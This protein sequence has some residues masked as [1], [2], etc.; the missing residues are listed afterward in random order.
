MISN[1]LID[2]KSR[3]PAYS[4]N[5][6][7]NY[8]DRQVAVKTGTTNDYKDVWVV[9][10]T[11]SL[12]LGMWGG[13]NDNAPVTRTAGTVLSPSW[14]KSMDAALTK[15][16]IEYF[17]TPTYPE[18]IPAYLSGST[19]INGQ[20]QPL[21]YYLNGPSDPQ[22]N[23]W[24]NPIQKWNNEKGVCYSQSQN[25]NPNNNSTTTPIN[26]NTTNNSTSTN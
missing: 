16:S 1:V 3:Y 6:P 2:S 23:L 8:Y 9:G 15:Y 14:R 19:C 21:V 12:V 18:N 25:S 10:Y 13:N 7:I 17:D 20:A 11:P 5:N 24:N 26:T 22:Y 4:V